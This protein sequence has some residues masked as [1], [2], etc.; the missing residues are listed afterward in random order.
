MEI[1]SFISKNECE[2]LNESDDHPMVHCLTNGG[3]FLQSDCDEQ[4]II[5][6]TFNQPMK[7]H[8]LK[9][10]APGNLGPKNI[11]LFINQPRT[12]D[13]DMADSCVSVQ[14]LLLEPKDLEGNTVNL[15]FVKFQNVQNIQ[16]FIM[17]NQSGGEITQIDYLGF[18][19]AP[20]STTKMEDFKRVAGKK[21]ESH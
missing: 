3:G 5:S 10:K 9:F 1:G 13:F 12:M 14:N 11:K 15:R 21:G 4:L 6:I 2:C 17:N 16:L 20:I 19:G 8:S 18:I 7:I